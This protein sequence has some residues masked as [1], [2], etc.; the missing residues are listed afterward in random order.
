METDLRESLLLYSY[1]LP[2]KLW[3]VSIGVIEGVVV[4]TDQVLTF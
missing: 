4:C 1:A 2:E 3:G